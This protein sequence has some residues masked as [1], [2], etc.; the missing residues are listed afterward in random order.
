M[1]NVVSARTIVVN[2]L[3]VSFLLLHVPLWAW[4]SKYLKRG[5]ADVKFG[6]STKRLLPTVIV[7]LI[8]FVLQQ[9]STTWRS[10]HFNAQLS[11]NPVLLG[12]LNEP[13][14]EWLTCVSTPNS[15]LCPKKSINVD[16]LFRKKPEPKHFLSRRAHLQTPQESTTRR[17][18][19][20]TRRT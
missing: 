19:T 14:T 12:S 11:G 3:V 16:S 5:K 4:H 9:N 8:F 13:I 7:W 10:W 1:S 20:E 2:H 18:N 15:I 6:F 17:Y